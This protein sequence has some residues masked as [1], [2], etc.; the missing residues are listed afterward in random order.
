MRMPSKESKKLTKKKEEQH[1]PSH[2]H[3]LN[4][5][6]ATDHMICWKTNSDHANNVPVSF[7]AEENV[8]RNIGRERGMGTKI[9]VQRSQNKILRKQHE[10]EKEKNKKQI[11]KK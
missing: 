6:L 8:K 4:V 7:T 9:I 10:T 1:P 3:P 2:Q 11:I 5:P